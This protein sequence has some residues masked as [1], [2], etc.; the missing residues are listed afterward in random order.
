MT[1]ITMTVAIDFQQT[2]EKPPD[3]T[4]CWHIIRCIGEAELPSTTG[5]LEVEVLESRNVADSDWFAGTSDPYV[6]L[7]MLPVTKQIN[8]TTKRLEQAKTKIYKNA[9]STVEI[10]ETFM[11]PM[12]SSSLPD[13]NSGKS[14]VRARAGNL[15]LKMEMKDKD[16]VFDDPIGIFALDL[17]QYLKAGIKN[18]PMKTG[19]THLYKNLKSTDDANAHK[20][21]IWYKAKFRPAA[22]I[23]RN[24]TTEEETQNDVAKAGPEALKRCLSQ[25]T[26]KCQI[27]V[28]DAKNLVN[29]EG[30]LGGK[31]DPYVQIRIIANDSTDLR[32]NNANKDHW[33]ETTCKDGAGKAPFWHEW[34]E[35]PWNDD[36]K[37]VDVSDLSALVVVWDKNMITSTLIGAA[38]IPLLDLLGSHGGN[39]FDIYAGEKVD[40]AIAGGKKGGQIRLAALFVPA[41][42][43]LEKVKPY[44]IPSGSFS[45]YAG[46][47]SY[48]DIQSSKKNKDTSEDFKLVITDLSKDVDSSIETSTVN[49]R[50]KGKSMFA[51]N[52]KLNGDIKYVV[53]EKDNVSSKFKIDLVAESSSKSKQIVASTTIPSDV[54]YSAYKISTICGNPSQKNGC[55]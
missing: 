18:I 4:R 15:K 29:V 23:I 9:G 11:F 22:E 13:Y 39:F 14:K 48:S 38:K 8:E 45:F 52:R 49:A 41:P 5:I 34:L 55:P 30:I 46:S 47:V 35:L 43:P 1:K 26:G 6:H 33:D 32:R 36:L 2:S 28:M 19:H 25:R 31:Q 3:R 27:L 51:F 10:N 20:T 53:S 16:M 17:R 44:P 54:L 24:V 42:K 12:F 7:Q 21:T 50:I 37:N 40:D